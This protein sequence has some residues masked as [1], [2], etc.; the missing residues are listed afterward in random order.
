MSAEEALKSSW[1][2]EDPEA[3]K[4]EDFPL[5]PAKS[6]KNKRPRAVAQQDVEVVCPSVAHI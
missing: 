2:T 1:F 5:Y 4:P 3:A 6:E